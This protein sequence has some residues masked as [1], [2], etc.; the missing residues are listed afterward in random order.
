MKVFVEGQGVPP[1]IEMDGYDDVAIHV[2]CLADGRV[3]GTGR[4]VELP[5]GMKLGRVAVLP[6]FRGRG[7][8]TAIVNW[9]LARAH[10]SGHN[11]VYANVQVSAR[12]FYEKL[13]FRVEGELFMEAG[14]EH[15]RMVR[16][17]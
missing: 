12:A 3:A 4:L 14:I 5:D 8:G 10:G 17:A 15:V 2:I 6:E 13:G 7:A 16:R 9:L 1:D 11:R